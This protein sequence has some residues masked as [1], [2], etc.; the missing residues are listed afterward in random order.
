[1]TEPSGIETGKTGNGERLQARIG[2]RPETL[3]AFCER[4]QVTELALFGSVLRDD[5]G[6]DSDIDLLIGFEIGQS[7]GLFG[8]VEMEDELAELSGRRVDL[9]SR[10][11]VENSRNHIRRKAILDSAQVVYAAR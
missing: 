8:I 7:P 9:V 10:R 3:A 2:L 11:A 4:W 6:P 5:F 1:M